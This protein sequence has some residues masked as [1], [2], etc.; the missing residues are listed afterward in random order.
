MKE[1]HQN[2]SLYYE[3]L[4]LEQEIAKRKADGK[5][6]DKENKEM[7]TSLKITDFLSKL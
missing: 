6:K 7:V 2:R 1:K 4:K 5:L 3:N